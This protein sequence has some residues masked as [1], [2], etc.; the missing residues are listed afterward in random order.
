[1]THATFVMGSSSIV[2]DYDLEWSCVKGED[3]PPESFLHGLCDFDG[4]VPVPIDMECDKDVGARRKQ[5]AYGIDS[6]LLK[7][8]KFSVL[9]PFRYQAC[10]R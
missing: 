8:I 5:T 2:S 10:S 3:V 4:S 9:G 7:H 1:M 6:E